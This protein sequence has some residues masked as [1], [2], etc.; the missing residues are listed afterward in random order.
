[1]LD[2]RL[3]RL[4]NSVNPRKDDKNGASSIGVTKTDSCFHSD[5]IPINRCF[6][7]HLQTEYFLILKFSF[8]FSF[9]FFNYVFNFFETVIC[10]QQFIILLQN[11]S[12][13]EKLII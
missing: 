5:L 10:Y 11:L 8:F 13:E 3:I 2:S 12:V 4:R 6:L 9:F 1:M 7:Q